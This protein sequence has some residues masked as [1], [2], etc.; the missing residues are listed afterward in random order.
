MLSNGQHICRYFTQ[1]LQGHL[2]RTHTEIRLASQNFEDETY[3]R[4]HGAT[5]GVNFIKDVQ[6]GRFPRA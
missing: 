4:T 1:Q 6:L 2:D 5:L 3:G